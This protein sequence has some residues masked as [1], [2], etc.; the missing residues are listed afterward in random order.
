MKE[1]R[2]HAELGIIAGAAAL[3]TIFWKLGIAVGLTAATTGC[4]QAIGVKSM[5]LWGA[6]F[7][8][9]NGFDISAGVQQYDRVDNNKGIG[10]FE[11][12]Q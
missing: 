8:A 7:E 11:K 3:A 5:D 10:S 1:Q 2:G 9:N 6:K 12:K 4:M